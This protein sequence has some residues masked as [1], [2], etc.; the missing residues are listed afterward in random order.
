LFGLA[1]F[2]HAN[3]IPAGDLFSGPLAAFRTDSALDIDPM[4]DTDLSRLAGELARV[5]RS[6]P[7]ALRVFDLCDGVVDVR[8]FRE[9]ALTSVSRRRVLG[10]AGEQCVL[11]AA[12]AAIDHPITN[13]RGLCKTSTIT[14]NRVDFPDIE[15][16]GDTPRQIIGNGPSAR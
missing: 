1:G 9:K 2:D 12:N 11:G 10:L 13:L 7:T 5:Y 16:T 4:S 6:G 3:G 8:T 15:E 14:I